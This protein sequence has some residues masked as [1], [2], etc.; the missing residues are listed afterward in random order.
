MPFAHEISVIV[1]R[2]KDGKTVTYGPMLNIHK[3]HILD[4]TTYPSGLPD[5][6]CEKAIAMTTSLANAVNLQGVLTLEMFVTEDGDILANEIAPRTHNSGHWTIEA[7]AASQF[8][9]HVRTVCDLPATAPGPIQPAKM[10]NLIGED[11]LNTASYE[12]K[13]NTYIHN[14][15]KTDAKPGR[16]MGHVTILET[17]EE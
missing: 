4:V 16:K 1:A 17:I 14:Y 2:D 6:V 11:I 15:G 9:N 7:C 10:I 8:E 3:N 5:A 12:G 13:P